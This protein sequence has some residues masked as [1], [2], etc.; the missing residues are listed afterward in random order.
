MQDKDSSFDIIELQNIQ[1]DAFKDAQCSNNQSYQ[2]KLKSNSASKKHYQYLSQTSYTEEK[3]NLNPRNAVHFQEFKKEI[4]QMSYSERIKAFFSNATYNMKTFSKSSWK[5]VKINSKHPY[6]RLFEK[7]FYYDDRNPE[8]ENNNFLKYHERVIWFSYRN[9]FPLIRDVADDNQSVSN[10]YGWGCMIRCSQMLLAEALKRHYLNDQN[11]QIEQLSQDDEKHFYSNIIK[12]FLDCTSES[13]VLN[14]PG[15]YQDIQSKMLLN[16]QNLNN[17]YSLFGIQNICQSAIL[18][19]YQQN[20]KNWYTSIQVSVILQEIL[21]ESQSKLNSKL[22]FHILNFTDQIIFLKELEEASRKQNDRL[23]NIL[24]M[25]HLKFGINK[26]EMQHKDYFIEL[27]KIKNFVGALSGTETKGMYII[28]FQEDR[29]IVLDPHFIQKSTEGEQGLDKDYCTYFNKTPRSI[30]LECLSSD[31]SL[32]YFIQVNEEQSIN[33]FIDQILTLNEKHKEPL[34]S[35]LNDRI[36]TDEMEIEEHQINKEVKDQ[37]NQDSVNNISQNEE[38]EEQKQSSEHNQNIDQINDIYKKEIKED[39]N[40]RVINKNIDK[41]SII[42][43]ESNFSHLNSNNNN[44]HSNIN[45]SNINYRIQD[46]YISNGSAISESSNSNLDKNQSYNEQEQMSLAIPCI[47]KL[48][49]SSQ[50]DNLKIQNKDYSDSNKTIQKN[51]VYN[52]FEVIS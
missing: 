30:S 1:A 50:L 42:S 52:D 41:Q 15:S 23:N 10:D 49:M 8:Q 28:G 14:Q 19:Q 20:V 31:I 18:R 32:G 33:Q 51:V 16:E 6:A 46:F 29:L 44:N 13:D 7:D 48:N 37:E 25:V 21:E 40:R 36:E 4:K 45:S 47:K 12:L 26:F 2:D 11:I 17:I 5:A 3:N 43:N 38:G 39:K 24:V 34:L 35:I 22:G 27:L 9:N